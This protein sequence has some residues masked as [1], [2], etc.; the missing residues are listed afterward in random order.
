MLGDDRKCK[1]QSANLWIGH[2]LTEAMCA[3]VD[4]LPSSSQLLSCAVAVE[5]PGNKQW[6]RSLNHYMK[7][8]LVQ[9]MSLKTTAIRVISEQFVAGD[10]GPGLSCQCSNS[11]ATTMATTSRASKEWWLPWVRWLEC[12]ARGT[13]MLSCTDL[14]DLCILHR[15]I[16]PTTLLA[17]FMII[18]IMYLV[19]IKVVNSMSHSIIHEYNNRS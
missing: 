9:W 16:L 17:I 18:S 15:H 3:I 4:L 19:L 11:W 12:T 7:W 8:Y 2:N 1:H 6:H 10:R 14:V 5:E 13:Q